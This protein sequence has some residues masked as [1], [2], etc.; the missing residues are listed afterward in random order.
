MHIPLLSP[1]HSVGLDILL[2]LSVLAMGTPALAGLVR[3]GAARRSI[4]V[5]VRVQNR[6]RRLR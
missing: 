1:G 5:A 4:P 3:L 2:L 6:G